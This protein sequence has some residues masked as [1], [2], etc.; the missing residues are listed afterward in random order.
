MKRNLDLSR[1]RV[2]G[3]TIPSAW[4]RNIRSAG[5]I[6]QWTAIHLLSEVYQH[7]RPSLCPRTGETIHQ[8]HLMEIDYDGLLQRLGF[9]AK[10]ISHSIDL[11]TERGLIT[12]STR[13]F[14]VGGSFVTRTYVDI[15][16]EA[17]YDVTEPAIAD[18]QIETCCMA[19]PCQGECEHSFLLRNSTGDLESTGELRNFTGVLEMTNSLPGSTEE[20]S[21]LDT[22]VVGL[23]ID[24]QEDGEAADTRVVELKNDLR[25]NTDVVLRACVPACEDLN[26]NILTNLTNMHDTRGNGSGESKGS[27]AEPVVWPKREVIRRQPP[28]ARS[29][30]RIAMVDGWNE[31]L[32]PLL[33]VLVDACGATAIALGP[34]A[35]D[36][37]Y[38][39]AQE[40]AVVMHRA[41]YAVTDVEWLSKM[42]YALDWRGQ[43][44]QKPSSAQLRA[45]AGEMMNYKGLT[46][47]EVL[48]AR[49]LAVDSAVASV[50]K[51]PAPE[52]EE[53]VLGNDP[54]NLRRSLQ[55]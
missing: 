28:S 31:D 40:F 33:K 29:D 35:D 5:G 19:T 20:A 17:L 43:K 30:R 25:E 36:R 11:L 9:T 34:L 54:Y 49:K 13:I 42:W 22:R 41:G 16:L 51:K 55:K 12:P 18:S 53:Y 14:N 47:G 27:E 32:F 4:V 46:P 39:Y 52:P 38:G 1:W 10:M 23:N 2:D 3:G 15:N 24:L 21:T 37:N 44:G 26:T 50:S 7:Y 8:D 45:F 48:A 6:P